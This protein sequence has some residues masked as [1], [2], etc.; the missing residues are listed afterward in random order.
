MAPPHRVELSPINAGDPAEMERGIAAFARFPNAGLIV[1]VGGTAVRRDVIIAGRLPVSLLRQ[2][3][4]SDL[5]WARYDRAILAR[6]GLCRSHL[7]RREACQS[8]RA[9]ADKVPA[10]G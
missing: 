7:Q 4:R 6:R 8:A 5:V 10:G 3:W 2:R 1:T 9:G